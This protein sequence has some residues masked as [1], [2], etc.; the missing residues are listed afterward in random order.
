MLGACVNEMQPGARQVSTKDVYLT[1]RSVRALLWLVDGFL[2]QL[3]RSHSVGSLPTMKVSL[4]H[5]KYNSAPGSRVG[6]PAYLAPEVVLT[7]RGKTYN[8]K[9]P[10]SLMVAQPLHN[11]YI[12]SL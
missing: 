12:P 8:A 7:T 5:E 2:T 6:T 1:R 4:Q 9:V 11:L 10:S 3:C